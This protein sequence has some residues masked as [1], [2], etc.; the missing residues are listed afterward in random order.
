M[1]LFVYITDAEEFLNGEGRGLTLRPSNE[2]APDIWIEAGSIEL[3]LDIDQSTVRQKAVETIE[4]LMQLKRE[5]FSNGMEEL[6]R[7]KQELLSI[8]HQPAATTSGDQ[9]ESK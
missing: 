1:K 2:N 3:E 4:R 7:R 5:D 9:A 8:P 6:S